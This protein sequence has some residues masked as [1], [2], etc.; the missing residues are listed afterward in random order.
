[1]KRDLLGLVQGLQREHLY[2]QDEFSPPLD[3]INRKY[4]L[5]LARQVLEDS[6]F[7]EEDWDLQYESVEPQ[8]SH[9]TEQ[10]VL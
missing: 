2:T 8:K 7:K 4:C 5:L 1:M 3:L 10:L 6:Q 9:Q